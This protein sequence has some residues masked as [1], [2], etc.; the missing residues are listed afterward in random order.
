MG[1]Q[2][3]GAGFRVQTSGHP[4]HDQFRYMFFYM[5]GFGVFTGQ[6]MPISNEKIT[7]VVFL[8][9]NP[10]F[11]NPKVMTEVQGACG[12]HTGDY[13][14]CA[15]HYRKPLDSGFSFKGAREL[16]LVRK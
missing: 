8:Q 12:A 13:S 1:L 11:Q 14:L 10:V 7:I 9:F 16:K 2:K 4:V 3:D 6:G 5:L 15:A